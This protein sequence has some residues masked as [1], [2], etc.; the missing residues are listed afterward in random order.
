MKIV[1]LADNRKNERLV[2]WCIAYK[3]ILARHELLSVSQVQK[4]IETQAGLQVNGIATDVTAGTNQIA[5]RAEYNEV[6]AVIYLHD[7]KSDSYADKTLIMR[8][9]D[10]NNIPYASN[11]ASAE[12]LILAIDR[13]DLDWRDL[14]H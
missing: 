2:N 10:T 9:C 8:A 7:P 3:Q 14:V 5:A 4:T 13:G 11:L 6:D 1:L 12:L